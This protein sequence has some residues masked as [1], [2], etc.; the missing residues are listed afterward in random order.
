MTL[1][2]GKILKEVDYSDTAPLRAFRL[3]KVVEPMMKADEIR[4]S[5]NKASR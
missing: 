5:S 1:R 4:A 3:G 2:D